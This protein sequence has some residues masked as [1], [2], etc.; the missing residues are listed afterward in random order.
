M[1]GSLFSGLHR[2]CCR[3]R[4]LAC[5]LLIIV[6]GIWFVF[7]CFCFF[8]V[9][10]CP[11]LSY[12]LFA[13]LRG[14][15]LLPI[16]AFPSR[17]RLGRMFFLE[18]GICSRSVILKLRY[19]RQTYIRYIVCLLRNLITTRCTKCSTRTWLSQLFYR[20]KIFTQTPF[21][22]P[23]NISKSFCSIFWFISIQQ[24]GK[25]NIYF[26]LFCELALNSDNF[27]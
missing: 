20:I 9:F 13:F 1:Y 7:V 15:S 23:P 25:K 10:V 2:V 12:F 6:L 27:Q 14:T 26:I 18:T 11:F 3:D 5:F 19:S 22:T 8:I 16:H 24:T 21:D 17:R 4:G